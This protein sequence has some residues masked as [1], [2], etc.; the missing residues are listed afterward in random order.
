MVSTFNSI[1][2]SKRSLHVQVAREIARGILSGE[3]PQ[4]SIIPGEMALCEQFGISRTALREAVKLL[5]SKGLLESRPKIG[6]RVVDRAYWNFLDPQLI[7]WMDG[8]TDI[9][10]FCSQFL[11]LRRAIEPE[12]CALAAK[13][14]TAEQRIELSEIFQKMVEVDAAEVFDQ[15][16]WTNIDIRFHSLIFNATG[17]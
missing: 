15:E 2:G 3:L 13:F 4:G 11:G 5:T 6:T 7:E 14:A 9:D 17:N 1:S 10:Q 8:L 12:A 16:S